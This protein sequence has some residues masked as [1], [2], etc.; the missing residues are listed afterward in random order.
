MTQQDVANGCADVWQAT[1]IPSTGWRM[2]TINELRTI[3]ALK[4]ELTDV[5]LPVTE[6]FWSTSYYPGTTDP[7]AVTVQNSIQSRGL[8]G[9]CVRDLPG[10]YT[11]E[12]TA[13]ET[14][15]D[16]EPVLVMGDSKIVLSSPV[17]LQFDIS[18]AARA[19]KCASHW[20]NDD[21][22]LSWRALSVHEIYRAYY[23]LPETMKGVQVLYGKRDNTWFSYGQ[24]D[25]GYILKIYH[26]GGE[27][28]EWI[29]ARKYIPN[30]KTT[31]IPAFKINVRTVDSN[32]IVC[33]HTG[34]NKSNAGNIRALSHTPDYT[35]PTTNGGINDGWCENEVSKAFQVRVLSTTGNWYA[36]KQACDNLGSGWRMPS[37]KEGRIICDWWI[38]VGTGGDH[39][40]WG[41]GKVWWHHDGF[42]AIY[43][44]SNKDETPA[45]KIVDFWTYDV[46]REVFEVGQ[47]HTDKFIWKWSYEGE[48]TSDGWTKGWD[49]RKIKFEWA[50]R[51]RTNQTAG[52]VCIRD[53]NL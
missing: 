41:T 35:S 15:S 10:T 22:W 24:A 8:Y 9:I 34:E 45:Q 3:I 16:G 40:P 13:G 52:T 32:I 42:W 47:T 25:D 48:E 26:S 33:E 12:N 38:N 30:V 53:V 36:A 7:V 43:Y 23:A 11:T 50:C 18:E 31:Y 21:L 28:S 1:E 2:P 4:D 29:C 46:P 37:K 44:N 51:Q 49:T 6:G 39:S 17:F 27:M 20:Q 5:S 14:S 19:T